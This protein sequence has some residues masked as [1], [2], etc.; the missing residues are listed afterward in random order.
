ARVAPA[1]LPHGRVGLVHHVHIDSP[2]ANP[3][4]RLERFENPATLGAAG[5]QAVL[6]H[7]EA[8]GGSD[9]GR[10]AALLLCPGAAAGGTGGGGGVGAAFPGA[11]AAAESKNR[12]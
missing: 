3:Q 1:V 5:T 12:V 7:F 9:A 10:A 2:A 11:G 6:D 4:R 8:N